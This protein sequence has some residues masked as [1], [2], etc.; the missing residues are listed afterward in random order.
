MDSTQTLRHGPLTGGG[1]LPSGPDGEIAGYGYVELGLPSGLKWATQNIGADSPSD[2][3]DYY[4]WGETAVKQEYTEENAGLYGKRMDDMAESPAYDVARA[5]WGG[6]WRMPTK[7]EC[8]EL[9]D[10][11]CWT[12]TDYNGHAGYRVTG[13]NGRS[14]FLPAAGY[15]RCSDVYRDGKDGIYW[16]STPDEDGTF[17]FSLY[18]FDDCRFAGKF[19]RS[20]GYQVRA[21]AE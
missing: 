11:C 17:A 15:R 13:R 18:L 4:A 5:R 16:S 7:E 19:L 14:I 10:E 1:K 21:V 20:L 3:G 9:L 8:E 12:W 2:Y 6:S